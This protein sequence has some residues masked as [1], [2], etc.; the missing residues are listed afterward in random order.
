MQE[1]INAIGNDI[2]ILKEQVSFAEGQS[3]LLRK[4]E[5]ELRTTLVKAQND[6][7]KYTKVIPFIEQ[8]STCAREQA[9]TRIESLLTTA[10]RIAMNDQN[11]DFTIPMEINR[12]Q[13]EAEF[14][15]D[16]RGVAGPIEDTFGNSLIDVM[17]TFM[18]VII[19]HLAGIKGPVVLDEPFRMLDADNQQ[20]AGEFLVK[21]L[22]ELGRQGICITHSPVLANQADRVYRVIKADDVSEV[23]NE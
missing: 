1:Q 14:V 10:I 16:N 22:K 9:K 2:T 4:K 6:I 15:I 3:Q 7:I 23:T 20:S 8:C 17:D 19:G 11:F 13:L 21:L 5:S 12:G 18:M